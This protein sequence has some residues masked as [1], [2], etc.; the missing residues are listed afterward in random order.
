MKHSIL[1]FLVAC[2]VS[3][4]AFSQIV[5]SGVSP[6][7]IAGNFDFT[8][9]TAASGWSTPDFNVAGTYVQAPLLLADDGTVG[10]DANGN[11][12][13]AQACSALTGSATGKIVILNRGTCGFSN[14]ALNA[15]NAGAVGV[16]IVNNAPGV[17]PITM[18]GGTEGA[19][20]TIPVVMI[21]YEDGETLQAEMLNGPVVMLLGNTQGLY[22]DDLAIN[23]EEYFTSPFAS[24]PSTI[25]NR[26]SVAA[27]IKNYGQNTQS[28]FDFTATITG[29][30]GLVYSDV[31]TIS[32]LA[33]GDSIS[34]LFA[35]F[36]LG[37]PG[38]YEEGG[39]TLT[40]SISLPGDDSPSNNMV[41]SAFK[42]QDAT[43]SRATSDGNNKPTATDYFRSTAAVSSYTSCMSFQDANADNFAVEGMYFM[44]STA[45][46][47][48]VGTQFVVQ[49]I[50]WDDPDATTFDF[51]NSVWD[52]TYSPASESEE[53]TAMYADFGGQ[54]QLVA[55]QRYL[56][57]VT[58][59]NM[60]I[61]FGF[62]ASTKLLFT[63]Q[64]ADVPFAPINIDGQWY[65]LG[66]TGQSSAPAIGLKM[67]DCLSPATPSFAAISS[68]CAGGSVP[69]L[70]TTSSNGI[71]GTWNPA[72]FSSASAGTY[73]AT[74]TPDAGQCATTATASLSVSNP[75]T[76]TF[77]PLTPICQGDAA[78]TLNT[79]STNSI[80]GSWNPASFSSASEGTFTATFT[81]GAGQC[82]TSTTTSLTVNAPATPTFTALAAVCQ[83]GSV[84]TLNGSST[85][86]VS[87]TWNPSTFSSAAAG[88][89]SST[90]T[91]NGG[92]CASTTTISLTINSPGTIPVFNALSA[93]CQGG[94]APAL[95]TVS[96]NGISGTWNPSI[97]NTS[98]PGSVTSTFTPDAGQCA[99]TA[100]ASLTIDAAVT[101]TFTTPLA[102]CQG[103][104][105]PTLPGASNNGIVGSWTPTAFDTSVSG[106]STCTFAATDGSCSTTATLSL[107]VSPIVTPTFTAL[108]SACQGAAAPALPAASNEGLG[109]TWNPSVFSTVV[110]G[111]FTSTFTPEAGS[112][113]TTATTSL[114]VNSTPLAPLV[115]SNNPVCIGETIT[116][117]TTAISGTY[118]WTGPNGFLSTAMN[119]SIP[120][121]TLAN[122]GTY[123][124]M[125]TIN[126]CTS[127]AGTGAVTVEDCEAGISEKSNFAINVYPNPSSAY[128]T[129]DSGDNVIINIEI[130]D[131]SGK[132][133]PA[134]ISTLNQQFTV[135]MA[136]QA[137]GTYLLRIQTEQGT[138][139]ARIQLVH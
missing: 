35:D 65:T 8:W 79:T 114:T 9:A 125:I 64:Y 67:N 69:A 27:E 39:Y 50:A 113:A 76:P 53:M 89:F 86:G 31:L 22:A 41:S 28:A 4:S 100:T 135:N 38:D 138:G 119:P 75:V 45:T 102:V 107:T 52:G 118:S 92:Q 133:V 101:P 54:I 83:G 91:P 66:F 14:K 40:Y 26:F 55:D 94:A 129:V 124:L 80:S 104:T 47:P 95:N 78:P 82:G 44:A 131:L 106:I 128:F 13:S 73:T 120:S 74:F 60:D 36:D 98:S 132:T 117:S 121:A 63:N 112:C 111:T 126:G 16:I 137:D 130:T 68:I 18:G 59:D 32:T 99:T 34:P 108:T 6:A 90:F 37:N 122:T 29:P 81:P 10:T 11:F 115:L 1:L 84:P 48:L 24:A 97:F 109:G 71:T 116:L 61:G 57:C 5:C 136:G 17:A 123:S 88:T 23:S 56:F 20:V 46:G 51:L 33:P 25:D 3:L 103:S 127:P 49:V 21:S 72:T 139:L 7:A 58:T 87:G 2:T 110:S 77:S 85:N 93:T 19:N 15:Q 62:D 12:L 42:I 30:S 134:T 43:I 105:P 70:N 96:N